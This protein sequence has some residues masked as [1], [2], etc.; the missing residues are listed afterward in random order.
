MQSGS[1]QLIKNAGRH[2]RILDI[3]EAPNFFGEMAILENSPRT[4]TVIALNEVKVLELDEKNFEKLML[5]NPAMAYK[6]LYNFAKRIYDSKRRFMILTLPDPQSKV[7]DVFVMLDETI[8]NQDKS[9]DSREFRISTEE[10]AR[11]AGI[12]VPQTREALS[13]F[14]AQQRITI[15]PNNIT[16]RNINDFSRFV[17]AKRN[18]E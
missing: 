12:S 5:G 2:E 1:V 16:V 11:W 18:Q 7:A 3:M 10:V 13:T 9:G 15:N 6:L 14:A 4:A 8:N 17:H